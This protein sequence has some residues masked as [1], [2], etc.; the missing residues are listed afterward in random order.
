MQVTSFD[1]S[2][3][4]MP[5]ISRVITV[6]KKTKYMLL[7][8]EHEIPCLSSPEKCWVYFLLFCSVLFVWGFFWLV[9]LVSFF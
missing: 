9:G 1:E 7:E 8:R 6:R 5:S 2:C 3:L 4:E